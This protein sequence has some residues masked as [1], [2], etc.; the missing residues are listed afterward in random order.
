MCGTTIN[1]D[2][3][4]DDD[5]E[6]NDNLP[7]TC[8]VENDPS[9]T[10]A[11]KKLKIADGSTPDYVRINHEL[12]GNRLPIGTANLSVT[13]V[14]KMKLMKIVKINL[15]HVVFVP[16]LIKNNVLQMMTIVL[17]T[18]QIVKVHLIVT[19]FHTELANKKKV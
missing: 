13:D 8:C 19:G 9:N 3:D 5:D 1:H 17:R 12:M 15:P 14:K 10:G 2:D 11:T 4:D 7:D 16:Q 18:N 6:E